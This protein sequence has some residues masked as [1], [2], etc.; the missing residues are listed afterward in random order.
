MGNFLLT[1]QLLSSLL[2]PQLYPYTVADSL[3]YQ[4]S[5]ICLT[6]NASIAQLPNLDLLVCATEKDSI[7][8][9]RSGKTYTASLK[10]NEALPSIIVND[11]KITNVIDTDGWLFL[12]FTYNNL[13]ISYKGNILVGSPSRYNMGWD[14]SAILMEAINSQLSRTAVGS[15]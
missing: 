15:K 6:E 3:N 11:N 8:W 14:Y 2:N 12:N 4:L 10:L 9:N 5:K 13:R 7:I 1:T